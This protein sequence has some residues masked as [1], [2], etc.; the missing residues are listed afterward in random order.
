MTPEAHVYADPGE[1]EL[2]LPG[3]RM[4]FF[5]M[6]GEAEARTGYDCCNGNLEALKMCLRAGA[7][8]AMLKFPD[9][10]EELCIVHSKFYHGHM[11]GF[12][13]LLSDI[14]AVKF[15]FRKSAHFPSMFEDEEEFLKE[16][17]PEV[18]EAILEVVE[19]FENKKSRVPKQILS[20]KEV[21]EVFVNHLTV[22]GLKRSIDKFNIPDEAIVIV[23]RIED[24]YYEKLNWGVLLKEGEH[25]NNAIQLNGDMK[26]EIA[27]RERGE[28]PEYPEIKDPN[29]FICEDENILRELKDQYHPAWGVVGY[30]DKDFLFIDLHY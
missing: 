16:N 23:Q 30:E 9:G 27:R 24:V 22:G 12:V 18:W 2:D 10:T 11:S 7:F 3:A 20:E 26:K 4:S 15:A 17:Y 29:K 21:K 14:D 28:E 8:I 5:Y 19:N 1:S 13:V 25:Y 6:H